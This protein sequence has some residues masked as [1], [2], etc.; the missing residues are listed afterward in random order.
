MSLRV[1]V[2][3]HA[4]TPLLVHPRLIDMPL[5][6]ICSQVQYLGRVPPACPEKRGI[7]A[8]HADRLRENRL[9]R[10]RRAPPPRRDPTKKCRAKR[11]RIGTA[12][13]MS[14]QQAWP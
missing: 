12:D 14:A 10:N 7:V 3:S 4:R 13:G 1:A 2:A 9:S 8:R 5:H 11:L 6:Q